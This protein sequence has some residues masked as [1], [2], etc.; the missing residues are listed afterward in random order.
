MKSFITVIRILVA[1]LFIFSGLVKANDPVGLSYKMQE[2]FTVWGMSSFNSAALVFSVIMIA[3]E[4]I[5]GVAL[6]IGWYAKW[7]TWFLLLLIIFFT[8]LTG[9]A[10]L[11]GQFKAC[12]CFGDCIPIKS[13]QS[14]YKDVILLTLII[15]LLLGKRYITPTASPKV[16]WV[17]MISTIILSILIQIYTIDHLPIK[18][19]LSFKVGNNILE[20]RKYKSDSVVI[21]Y[22]YNKAG[23]AYKVTPPNYPTW[24][25]EGD[26][27]YIIDTASTVTKVIREGNKLDLIRDFTMTSISGTDSLES[28]LNQKGKMVLLIITNAS[29]LAKANNDILKLKEQCMLYTDTAMLAIPNSK[30]PLY[31]ITNQVADVTTYL[32]TSMPNLSN[33][34]IFFCDEKPLLAAARTRPAIMVV[35]DGTI[36]QKLSYHD[37]D[38]VALK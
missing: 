9:Y 22:T 18:D 23:K 20:K 6:L 1:V 37:F 4:I 11:S 35:S 34:H 12:G 15:A 28:I 7:V 36:L 38:K 33:S 5:A 24:M 8:F 32:K 14:F 29:A 26:T 21:T 16:N 31:I 3:L 25:L 13:N 27:T 10:W 19:C 30:P 17:L 2:F